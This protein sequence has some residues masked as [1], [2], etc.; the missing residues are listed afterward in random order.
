MDVNRI[1]E[2]N[3]KIEDVVLDALAE[4]VDDQVKKIAEKISC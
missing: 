1:Q 4:S 2:S 3:S